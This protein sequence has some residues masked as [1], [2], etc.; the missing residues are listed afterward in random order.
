MFW[1]IMALI[2]LFVGIFAPRFIPQEIGFMKKPLRYG[3]WLATLFFIAGTSYVYIGANNV[4][5]LKRVYGSTALTNGRIIATKGE[6]GYQ[7]DILRPG[8]HVIPFLTVFYDVED[9]PVVSIPAG[10]YGRI[11]TRD[12]KPLPHGAIMAAPWSDDTF[13][14]MLDAKYFL[15]NGGEKGL[16]TAV[17]KPGK[18]PLNLYLYRVRVGNGKEGYVCS[19]NGCNDEETSLSTEQTIIPAGFV[20][21][22]T[23]VIDEPAEQCG[24]VEVKKVNAGINTIEGISEPEAG[25]LS[26]PLVKNGCK[27]IWE[28]AIYPGGYF[29]N[30]DAYRVTLVDTRV[31][32]WKYQGGYTS[33]SFQLKVDQKGNITQEETTEII[34]QPKDAADAA[35]TVKVEGWNVHQNLRALV[36]VT[37][38]NA[39]IVV[40]AVGSLKEVEDRVVTPAIWSEV[41]DVVGGSAPMPTFDDNG[42]QI[43]TDDGKPVLKIRAIKVLDVVEFREALQ[44]EVSRRM[45]HQ[46]LKAGVRVMEIRFG[47]PD[48]PPEML[49]ARKRQQV[50]DQLT[51]TFRQE[52]LSQIERIQTEKQRATADQQDDLV[53]Q[54]IANQKAVLKKEELK[55]LG[56]GEKFRLSEIA[57]GQKEQAD[58]LGPDRVMALKMLE[59][60]LATLERKPEL[61]SILPKL[62]P[63][64]LI[65]GGSS[66]EGF[67][68]VFGQ[69]LNRGSPMAMEQPT[70]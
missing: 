29:L 9:F 25:T 36:Q 6:M 49:V 16:Q 15:E 32:T 41:R 40:A 50:A 55:N 23:S 22:V 12:G 65:T 46:G 19:T 7:A 67:A 31:Q 13:A 57:L 11:E 47:N 14:K 54:Q 43:F 34:P 35:V 17:L 8:F 37:P 5:H 62:V 1:V 68:T 70:K 56:E 66:M 28:E 45:A 18:Y 52:R 38:E 51:V 30:R 44:A 61:I 59:Q 64:T 63:N 42:D 21:V 48:I 3:C 24:A 26:V 10:F 20:G 4:G 33:R 69:A 2:A 60:I 27:G 53:T 39:P 58:V